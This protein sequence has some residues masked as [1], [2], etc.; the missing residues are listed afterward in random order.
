MSAF[1]FYLPLSQSPG[2]GSTLV[3]RADDDTARDGRLLAAIRARLQTIEPRAT[4]E[5]AQFADEAYGLALA[6]PRFMTLILGMLAGLALLT[7]TVGI[8]AVLWY[9]VTQRT[10]ELGVRLALGARAGDVWR[11]VVAEAL[12][13]VCA[14]MCVGVGASLWLTR[15]IASQLYQVGPRDPVT[16]GLVLVFFIL[17]AIAAA[18]GPAWKATRVDPLVALRCEWSCLVGFTGEPTT[19][20]RP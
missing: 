10:P 1:R 5:N 20:T 6:S 4:I 9:T 16:I 17:V 13:P 14:G 2:G 11:L 7:A 8:Y 15:F 18:S 19:T 3:V 12:R